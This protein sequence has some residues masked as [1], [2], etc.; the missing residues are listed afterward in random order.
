[1]DIG[2]TLRGLLSQFQKGAESN[3]VISA[4]QG[5][6]RGLNAPSQDKI[7]EASKLADLSRKARVGMETLQQSGKPTQISQNP[8]LDLARKARMGMENMQGIIP[9]AQAQEPI[10]NIPENRILDVGKYQGA[11]DSEIPLPSQEIQDLLWKYFPDEATASAVAL[12]GENKGFNPNA[13][14]LN[15]NGTYDYG[16][17]QNNTATLREML[18]KGRYGN[19]LREGGINAPEDVLGDAEKSIL[20]S[21]V[22]RQ[23]E[24]DAGVDPWSWWYG[25]QNNGYNIN[26]ELDIQEVSQNPAYFKLAEFINKQ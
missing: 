16:L 22:T 21:K 1:M 24:N 25:W 9:Q 23:Y 6:L 18:G 7:N 3:K 13:K 11:S 5:G 15:A 4:I 19:Q 17:M 2:N 8:E 10:E 26:P 14:N 12:A 20:A